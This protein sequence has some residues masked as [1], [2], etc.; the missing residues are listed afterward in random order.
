MSISQHRIDKFMMLVR[1]CLRQ[2]LFTF[3]NCDWD[4]EYLEKFS[5]VLYSALTSFTLSLRT[6]IQ[7]I[8]LEELAKVSFL[9]Y[10]FNC[11]TIS[12]CM[13]YVFKVSKGKVPSEALVIILDAFLHYISELNDTMAIKEVTQNVFRNL[14]SQSP[15]MEILEEKFLAWRKVS[16]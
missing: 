15:D 1:R 5:E 6:H 2:V 9:F 16:N 10:I 12:K 14:L 3:V 8:F 7:E 4:R 13:L 11:V